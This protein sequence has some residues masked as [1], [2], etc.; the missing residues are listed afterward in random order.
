[1]FGEAKGWWVMVKAITPEQLWEVHESYNATNAKYESDEEKINR[2]IAYLNECLVQRAMD[3][4]WHE[5]SQRNDNLFPIETLPEVIQA[6]QIA[7]YEVEYNNY[8]ELGWC[9]NLG[10][11]SE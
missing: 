7:G 4:D 3:A 1:M 10:G 8:R 9:I 2:H 6:F 5:D 11:I